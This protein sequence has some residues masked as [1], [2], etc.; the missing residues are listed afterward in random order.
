MKT[1]A[2]IENLAKVAPQTK[3]QV[4]LHGKVWVYTAQETNEIFHHGF[5]PEKV[6]T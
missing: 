3:L 2:L 1:P 6:S 5:I 4:T